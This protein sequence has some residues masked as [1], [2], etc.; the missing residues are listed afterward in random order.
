M[1]TILMFFLLLTQSTAL[2]PHEKLKNSFAYIHDQLILLPAHNISI[3]HDI[4]QDAKEL[5]DAMSEAATLKG[6]G[7]VINKSYSGTEV[8]TN[9]H[10]CSSINPRKNIPDFFSKMK[11]YVESKVLE[12]N[13]IMNLYY[14]ISYEYIITDYQGNHYKLVKVK[15]TNIESDLCIIVSEGTWGTPLKV[16][17]P[18]C[19]PGDEVLNMSV[20]GG[21]Y[22]EN[23]VPTREGIYNGDIKNE[24][25]TSFVYS[26]RSLYTLSL[27][28]GASG[29]AVINRKG[30]LCG[31]I[32]HATK[33]LG[34]SYGAS[35]YEIRDFLK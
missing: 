35:V 27:Q 3:P 17:E 11:A 34:L 6:S 9:E 10:V 24:L 13:P 25:L 31:N 23:A 8:L 2:T 18:A 29:S 14:N 19:K 12:T 33:S 26:K 5:N 1:K 4:Q 15:K 30:H 16:D 28:S 20:S 22:Y 32:S 21:I 7:F